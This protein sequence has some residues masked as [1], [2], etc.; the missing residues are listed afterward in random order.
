MFGDMTFPCHKTVEYDEW[1][2]EEGEYIY[3]GK[4]QH[5]AG[6][7]IVLIKMESLWYNFK[8]RLA[9]VAKI[10]DPDKLNLKANTYSSMQEFID[11]TD[12]NGNS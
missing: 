10:F 12:K 5:C 2:Q 9:N 1:E 4:E 3:Q 6:A 7:L 11:A 8:L